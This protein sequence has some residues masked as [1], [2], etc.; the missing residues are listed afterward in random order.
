[1]TPDHTKLDRV[2]LGG[3]DSL[4]QA[5]SALLHRRQSP[6]LLV[7]ELSESQ[8]SGGNGGGVAP[9]GEGMMEPKGSER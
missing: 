9:L 1:M 3:K 4:R 2:T 7:V 5:T 8:K 6:T